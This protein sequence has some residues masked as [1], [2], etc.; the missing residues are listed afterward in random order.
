MANHDYIIS[1]VQFF[2]DKNDKNTRD[3]VVN[4]GIDLDSICKSK[5]PTISDIRI[6]STKFGL[7]VSDILISDDRIE[8]SATKNADSKIWMI[9]TDVE[10]EQF[11]VNMFEIGRGSDLNLTIDLIKYLGQTH[12]NFLFYND[13]G[14]MSL[15]TPQKENDFI[16]KEM[17]I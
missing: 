5:M 8:I 16:I 6:A 15:I 4:T 7:K 13:S 11:D 14:I 2:K 12:G 17:N 1:E 3:F 9:F 10:D